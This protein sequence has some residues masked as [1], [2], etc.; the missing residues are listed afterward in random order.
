MCEGAGVGPSG[1]LSRFSPL[2]SK[3]SRPAHRPQWK[4]LPSHPD[5]HEESGTDEGSSPGRAGGPAG[6][7]AVLHRQARLRVRF[8]GRACD[9]VVFLSCT[10]VP[11][12]PPTSSVS[13]PL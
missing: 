13:L 12:S 6:R 1:E 11:L 2:A 5:S 8:L 9:Q 7:R 4:F 10:H 3:T